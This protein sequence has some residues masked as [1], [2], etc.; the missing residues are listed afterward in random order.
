MVILVS[1]AAS[2]IV[3]ATFP[4]IPAKAGIHCGKSCAPPTT[5]DVLDYV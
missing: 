2:L 1:A 3:A 5:S 4:V